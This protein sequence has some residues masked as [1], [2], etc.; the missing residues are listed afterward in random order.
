M[1]YKGR[2]GEERERRNRDG[3]RRKRKKR[4][5]VDKKKIPRQRDKGRG[6]EE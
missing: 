3:K 6:K 1:V 4:W 5:K 2:G